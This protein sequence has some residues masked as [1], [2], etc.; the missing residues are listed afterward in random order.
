MP[1]ENQTHD[2]QKGMEKLIAETVVL[3]RMQA[4]KSSKFC[5]W[6]LI[7]AKD[8]QDTLMTEIELFI[9]YCFLLDFFCF[10]KKVN[11]Y[12]RRELTKTTESMLT[13][14]LILLKERDA[15]KAVNLYTLRAKIYNSAENQNDVTKW[16]LGTI[17]NLVANTIISIEEGAPHLKPGIPLT[18][19]PIQLVLFTS[20]LLEDISS[21]SNT[22]INLPLIQSLAEKIK[23][24]EIINNHT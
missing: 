13:A 15:Q 2:K 21:K 18:Q 7:E 3:L 1:E 22:I 4:E 14:F 24:V 11:E 6:L 17:E 9:Y 23:S 10:Q 12:A 5:P 20:T 16:L 8:D 19:N